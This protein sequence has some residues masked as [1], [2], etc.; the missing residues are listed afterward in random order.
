MILT[1][2]SVADALTAAADDYVV[3][4]EQAHSSIV[5]EI[6][7]DLPLVRGSVEHLR[8]AFSHLIDN[9]IK[10]SPE[11]GEV[12]LVAWANELLVH[13]SVQDQ[14]IG[15]APQHLEH[16]FERFYQADGSTTRRFGGM[17]IGLALV[18]EIV[19]AHDG[20]VQ[21][22]SKPN[23]GSTFTV[24]LPQAGEE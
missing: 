15:I 24:I 4:A 3:F 11:G 7:D 5:V 23:M 12:K 17:G 1:P 13:I 8:I 22:D 18:W 6:P 16:I 14:G 2:I 21:V 19:E 10:F 9:A 20:S